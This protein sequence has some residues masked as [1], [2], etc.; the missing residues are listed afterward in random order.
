NYDGNRS[1]F[2]DNS[3]SAGGANPD[4][5]AVF[6]AQRSSDNALTVMVI[7]KYLSGTTQVSLSLANFNPAGSAQVYQLTSTNT[8]T[9]LADLTVSGTGLSFIA[10]AQSITLLVLPQ[11]G[12]TN[13]PPTAIASATPTSG[14]SPLVVNFSSAG[15][16]D[17]DGTIASYSW[18]FG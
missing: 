2:G 4:N 12:V 3:V 14:Y 18:T 5:I 13:Q 6:A 11:S 17:P 9:R 10:P 8:I 15:S 16:S 1:S 7:A